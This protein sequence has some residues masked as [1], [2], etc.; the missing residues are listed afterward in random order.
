M[1]SRRP[2]KRIE[3]IPVH[4]EIEFPLH[5]QGITRPRFQQIS[6]MYHGIEVRFDKPD[7]CHAVVAMRNF[8]HEFQVK[9]RV[10]QVEREATTITGAEGIFAVE[11]YEC[12]LERDIQQ[13][14]FNEIIA[15]LHH[16]FLFELNS[17]ETSFLHVTPSFAS[18]GIISSV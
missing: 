15:T 17:A 3:L 1:T 14:A 6:K 18:Y 9:I 11:L 7:A 8:H 5:Q 16:A 4:E 13:P 2:K 10:A 12:P